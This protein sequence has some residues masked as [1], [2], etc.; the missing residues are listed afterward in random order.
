MLDIIV[1]RRQKKKYSFPCKME[2]LPDVN[3]VF[4]NNHLLL[5]TSALVPK[6]LSSIL[7]SFAIEIADPKH[8]STIEPLFRGMD[9]PL[10]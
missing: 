2:A 9:T 5:L 1:E 3:D 7:T 6:A 10:S 4:V 8:V